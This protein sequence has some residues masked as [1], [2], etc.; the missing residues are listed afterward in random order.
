MRYDIRLSIDY[1]YASPVGS[2][3]HLLRLMPQ[4][5]PEQ[6]RVSGLLTVEPPPRERTDRLDFFGNDVVEVVHTAPHS[7]ILFTVNA[8]VERVGPLTAMTDEFPMANMRAELAQFQSLDALSPHHFL[9]GSTRIKP[10]PVWRKYARSVV[11]A[12]LTVRAAVEAVGLAL[13]RDMTFD[14]GM[15]TVDTLPEDAFAR[16]VGVCQDYTQIM[17]GCLRAL[18][19]PAG[20]VSGFL[21]TEPPPGKKRLEG[22]DAMHAWVC[23]WCG[24]EEGWVEYDPTNAAFVLT[25]HISIGRGRDY[26]DVSPVRGMLKTAGKTV[27]SQAVDVLPLTS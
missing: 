6:R 20:Y 16:R 23:A 8:R 4:D 10:L 9:A 19:I 7:S 11:G 18:G 27:T 17:I 3:R 22:A 15:T 5:N 13:H 25:D 24:P 2:G 21:R 12:G 26:S 1:T 14:S